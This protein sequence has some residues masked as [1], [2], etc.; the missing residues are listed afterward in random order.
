MRDNL[1]R[2]WS[3]GLTTRPSE[4][5]RRQVFVNFWFEAEGI[6]LRHDIG[7]DNIMWESD[8]PHVASYY[9]RSWQGVHRVLEGVPPEDRRKL[10]YENAIRLYRIDAALPEKTLSGDALSWS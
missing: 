9:P 4:T 8:F 1:R 3:E 7:I 10:L 5:V 2:L 6:K